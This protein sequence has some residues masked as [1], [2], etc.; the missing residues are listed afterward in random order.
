MVKCPKCNKEI[1]HL[2]CE[3]S[4]LYR[5]KVR[6]PKDDFEKSAV[7]YEPDS[8]LMWI[9]VEDSNILD[10]KYICPECRE[11]ITLD[12]DEVRIFLE[13]GKLLDKP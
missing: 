3:T 10:D 13:T 6:L 1:D 2:V 9:P 11:T 5:T 7:E 8:G 4:E 12:D